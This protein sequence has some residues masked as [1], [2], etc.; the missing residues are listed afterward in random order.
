MKDLGYWKQLWG[1]LYVLYEDSKD[2]LKA[3]ENLA[4]GMWNL[5]LQACALAMSAVPYLRSLCENLKKLKSKL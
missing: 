2:E 1:E 3:L 4:R 5:G